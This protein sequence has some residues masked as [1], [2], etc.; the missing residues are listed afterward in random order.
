MAEEDAEEG[1]AKL[2]ML[3]LTGLLLS[4]VLIVKEGSFRKG[5]GDTLAL[6]LARTWCTLIPDRLF[7]L[8]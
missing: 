6:V 4:I 8:E 5:L 2:D 3:L 7:R 1:R